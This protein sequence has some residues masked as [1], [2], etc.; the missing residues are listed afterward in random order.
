MD[1]FGENRPDDLQQ[2]LEPGQSAK[3]N[4]DPPECSHLYQKYSRG[5]VLPS[6]QR[7]EA[8]KAIC[9]QADRVPRLSLWYALD[10]EADLTLDE[11]Q[12]IFKHLA[13][14]VSKLVW[15]RAPRAAEFPWSADTVLPRHTL[16]RPLVRTCS[17][18]ALTVLLQWMNDG[19]RYV[20]DGYVPEA[21]MCSVAHHAQDAFGRLSVFPPFN[22]IQV[23]LFNY[24]VQN[25]LNIEVGSRQVFTPMPE[26]QMLDLTNDAV[27]SLRLM[28]RVG[29]VGP[30]LTE[31]RKVVNWYFEKVS[32]VSKALLRERCLAATSAPVVIDPQNPVWR[33]LKQMRHP[34][35]RA[36]QPIHLPWKGRLVDDFRIANVLGPAE[37]DRSLLQK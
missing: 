10:P 17:A 9:C 35:T 8:W 4:P 24:L 2:R 28:G 18:D 14:A 21:A 19:L 29:L 31:Q 30:G 13:P 34:G 32:Q 23:H 22:S 37:A 1:I 25:F 27:Q 12:S 11:Y 6:D 26:E 16:L 36:D 15:K 33:A 20:R 5:E 7:I 3:E